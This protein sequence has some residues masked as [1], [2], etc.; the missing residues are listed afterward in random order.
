MFPGP[1]AVSPHPALVSSCPTCQRRSVACPQCGRRSVD[2]NDGHL[3]AWCRGC[4]ADLRSPHGDGRVPYE[5]LVR[6]VLGDGQ[7]SPRS[8]SLFLMGLAMACG[9]VASYFTSRV[10]QRPQEPPR[11]IVRET[12]SLAPPDSFWQFD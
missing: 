10:V 4:G 3:P 1:D 5:E 6:P 11:R 7:V 2:D 12:Y 8:A 9:L